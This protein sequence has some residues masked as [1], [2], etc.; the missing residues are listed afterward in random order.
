MG[1]SFLLLL[2]VESGMYWN[3]GLFSIEKDSLAC[4]V[5]W[6]VIKLVLVDR[7]FIS[8][9]VWNFLADL[10]FGVLDIY[11]VCFLVQSA[12][13][14]QMRSIISSCQSFTNLWVWFRNLI[15]RHLS[16]LWGFSLLLCGI[17]L[18]SRGYFWRNT[19]CW[20][21]ILWRQN[22]SRSCIPILPL[23]LPLKISFVVGFSCLDPMRP[24]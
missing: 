20:K 4:N 6:Y 16:W 22:G 23:C 15:M 10:R 9:L 17:L 2:L 7:E 21:W 24:A 19:M 11:K 5:G 14:L 1:I 18:H 12:T 8:D 3:E 13:W